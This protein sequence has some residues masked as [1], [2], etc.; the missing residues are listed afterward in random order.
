MT[1]ELNSLMCNFESVFDS[2]TKAE[3]TTLAGEMSTRRY[4]R[5]FVKTPTPHKKE[6][7]TEIPSYVFQASDMFQ[8]PH[9]HPFLLAQKIFDAIGIR[10]PKIIGTAG[11]EGWILVEDCG[12][13]FLQYRQEIDLYRQTID[14]LL[15]LQKKAKPEKKPE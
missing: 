8:D 13:F 11:H 6:K 15:K 10:V 12:D 1:P 2:S 5:I 14:M 7:S 3:G 4:Y 9:Q